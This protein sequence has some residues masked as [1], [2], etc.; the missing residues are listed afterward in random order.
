MAHTKLTKEELKAVLTNRLRLSSPRFRL[1]KLSGGKLS[2][3]VV[4]DFFKGMNDSERQRRIWEALDAEFGP[5]SMD[6][7][8][9]LLAYTDA[10]WDVDLAIK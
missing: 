5:E 8:G 3:S 4:S 1:E 2:G 9:T 7:V 6:L 10:E